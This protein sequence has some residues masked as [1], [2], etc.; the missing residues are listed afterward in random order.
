MAHQGNAVCESPGSE[1]WTLN[2][3]SESAAGGLTQSNVTAT[4]R[5]A[6]IAVTAPVAAAAHP[7]VSATLNGAV[8]VT[9]GPTR[10][11]TVRV[12]TTR[13]TP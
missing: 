2:H 8:A 11:S 3:W 13:R 1:T 7:F 9:N 12:T 6:G 4:C 10:A 5:A